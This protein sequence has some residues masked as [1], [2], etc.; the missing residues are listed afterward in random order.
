MVGEL[1]ILRLTSNEAGNIGPCTVACRS[2]STLYF[3]VHNPPGTLQ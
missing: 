2:T 1:V 3:H